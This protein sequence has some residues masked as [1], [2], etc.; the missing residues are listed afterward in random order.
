MKTLSCKAIVH[1]RNEKNIVESRIREIPGVKHIRDE[2]KIAPDTMDAAGEKLEDMA[3]TIKVMTKIL[4]RKELGSLDIH[5]K[6][7]QG[8]VTLSGKVNEADEK[9]LAEKIAHEVEGVTTVVNK[10]SIQG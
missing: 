2:V 7:E 6:A 9:E 1:T 5:V 3:T 8:I 4:V 10:L